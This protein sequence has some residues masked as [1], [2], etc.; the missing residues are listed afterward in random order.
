MREVCSV[1]GARGGR[2][3]YIHLHTSTYTSTY[4]YIHLYTSIYIYIYIYIH[5]H[6]HLYTSIYIYIH[7]Y[8]STR[9]PARPCALAAQAVPGTHPGPPGFCSHPH[10]ASPLFI[11]PT[12][13]LQGPSP[14][15]ACAYASA[16]VCRVKERGWV[17]C[18]PYCECVRA[19]SLTHDARTQA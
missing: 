4:I 18:I 7:L 14:P 2:S 15:R 8:T 9:A 1:V 11:R 17:V 13:A 16:R 5:L 10:R 12:R 6:I 19:C 3:A